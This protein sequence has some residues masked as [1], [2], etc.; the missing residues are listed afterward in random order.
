MR[1][2]LSR[3]GWE[4]LAADPDPSA[5]LG[6]DVAEWDVFKTGERGTSYLMFLPRDPELLGDDAFVVAEEEF[7][8]DL[9]FYV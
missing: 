3:Y 6:Y 1:R 7:V 2:P 4:Q 9:A 5:D 8:C